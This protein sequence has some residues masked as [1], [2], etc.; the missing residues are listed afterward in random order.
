MSIIIIIS[1][2]AVDKKKIKIPRIKIISIDDVN[3]TDKVSVIVDT[4][5]LKVIKPENLYLF[6]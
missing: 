2:R 6:K 4:L 5:L 1:F 3:I